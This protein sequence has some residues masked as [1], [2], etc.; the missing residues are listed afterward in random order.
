MTCIDVTVPP[1]AP[2]RPLI[3]VVA[4]LL[5]DGDGRILLS[6][7]PEGKSMAGLWEFPGG[8]VKPMETP[9]TALVRELHE[10]LGIET[11]TGCLSPLTFASHGYADFH[12]LMPVFAC[13][14]WTGTPHGAEGQALVWIYK[15][16]MT[17]YPMPAADEILRPLLFDL[18]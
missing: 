5:I 9:E 16:E 10:E 8:K 15:Q 14:Q 7:R 4:G 2:N 12:L 3:L 1:L 6:Q 13:R 17:D 18:L 11:S